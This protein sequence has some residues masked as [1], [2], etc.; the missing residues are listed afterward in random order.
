M[1][2]KK[3]QAKPAITEE[4]DDDILSLFSDEDE[5]K[6]ATDDLASDLTDCIETGI[7]PFDVIA[8]GGIYRGRTYEISG[9]ESHGKSTLA[10]SIAAAWLRHFPKGI[11]HI[12]ET[13]S[14]VDKQRLAHMGIDLSRV[15]ISE[16]DILEDGFDHIENVSRKVNDKYGE[17]RPVLH[18]WDTIS[19]ANSR[20]EKEGDEYAKGMME[21]PRIIKAA[22]RHLTLPL[23]QW[24]HNLILIQQVIDSLGYGGGV[25]TT[26]GRAIKHFASVRL[27]VKKREPI[28]EMINGVDTKIGNY[29]DIKMLKCKV[30]MPDF[31]ASTVML[32]QKGFIPQDSL[33]RYVAAGQ[34]APYIIKGGG[35][36]IKF[37]VPQEIAYA[38][39][40]KE[41][42]F[43][44]E[45]EFAQGLG[46]ALT[47]EVVKW[48]CYK[49][50][51]DR[52]ELMAIKYK[53]KIDAIWNNILELSK[54]R[55]K[56]E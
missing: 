13:E 18:I 53:D 55:T 3:K 43:H 21:K 19:A 48:Y 14:A 36:W 29:V 17:E 7:I 28:M 16:T 44:G 39:Q 30:A 37:E 52:F 51:A 11:I 50:Y 34:A 38:F 56:L 2:G 20:T 45:R 41:L 25:T 46:D 10:Y 54:D 47:F 27:F 22:L 42:S 4:L 24:K 1:A 15:F 49:S 33:A 26:G 8:G 23:A 5:V 12:I 32:A 31:T 40:D 9:E 35:G 6:I